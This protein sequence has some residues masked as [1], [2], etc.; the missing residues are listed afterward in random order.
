MKL[1]SQID[2]INKLNKLIGNEKTGNPR[3]LANRLGICESRLYCILDEL[4]LLNIPIAYCRKRESYYYSKPFK[5][6][7]SLHLI[8][9]T[10]EET[11]TINGG[12]INY[13][14]CRVVKTSFV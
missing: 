12:F 2:R 6:E 11:K 7:A 10:N 3:E 14:F 9:L 4:K 13:F 5:M 8:D 1:T